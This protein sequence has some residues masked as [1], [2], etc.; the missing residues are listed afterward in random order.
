MDVAECCVCVPTYRVRNREQARIPQLT[1][2]H[3][4][5]GAQRMFPANLGSQR[6]TD[7]RREPG[8]FQVSRLFAISERFSIGQREGLILTCEDR[9]AGTW[10]DNDMEQRCPSVP[11][12]PRADSEGETTRWDC[13]VFIFMTLLKFHSVPYYC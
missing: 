13:G 6:E 11:Q 3:P 12:A 9:W 7:G 4:Q 1:P 2:S 8:I 10:Q 5:R